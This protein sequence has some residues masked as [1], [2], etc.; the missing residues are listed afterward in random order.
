MGSKVRGYGAMGSSKIFEDL[1]MLE[2]NLDSIDVS[3]FF[4]GRIYDDLCAD[5]ADG[6]IFQI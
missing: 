5:D 3:S 1:E 4:L 2:E 6:P